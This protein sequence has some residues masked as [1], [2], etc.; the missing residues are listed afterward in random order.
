MPVDL[1]VQT[2]RRLHHQGIPSSHAALVSRTAT[3]AREGRPAD[4]PLVGGAC[5][6][7]RG[8]GSTSTCR[9]PCRP[10]R[11]SPPAVWSR[12]FDARRPGA[13]RTRIAFCPSTRQSKSRP[14]AF[15]GPPARARRWQR[16]WDIPAR[17]DGTKRRD[18]F[19]RPAKRSERRA[20]PHQAGG[21]VG[22][23]RGAP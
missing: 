4:P 21:A 23:W 11:P 5:L 3:P 19:P 16:E 18:S 7:L 22:L 6:R 20:A 12:E 15:S 14:A 1:G 2:R 9:L 13:C 10:A 8:P 17:R